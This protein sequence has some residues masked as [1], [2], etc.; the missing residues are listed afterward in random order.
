MTSQQDLLMF[1]K[2]KDG[3]HLEI[4][5]DLDWI[6]LAWTSGKSHPFREE[7]K[8][9]LPIKTFPLKYCNFLFLQAPFTR[10]IRK[11]SVATERVFGAAKAFLTKSSV[12]L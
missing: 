1:S 4:G 2:E 6:I 11:V 12:N 9:R 8:A 3:S 5:L 7:M 10:A